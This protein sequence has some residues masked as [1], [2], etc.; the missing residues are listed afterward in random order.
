MEAPVIVRGRL[1]D[2]IQ[3]VVNDLQATRRFYEAVFGVLGIAIGGEG[4]DY[5]WADELFVSSVDSR[6]AAGKPR[7]SIASPLSRL[8]PAGR[9]TA[10]PVSGRIT[11]ATTPPSCWIR[12]ATTSKW[13]TT[14]RPRAPPTPSESRSDTCALRPRGRSGRG[15][16]RLLGWRVLRHPAPARQPRHLRDIAH[17][18]QH[19]LGHGALRRRRS[20]VE[21]YRVR[22][23]GDVRRG[24]ARVLGDRSVAGCIR[25]VPEQIVHLGCPG[26][27]R[28]RKIAVLRGRAARQSRHAPC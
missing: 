10:A 18:P 17:L 6:A 27:A 15:P 3:L 25:T 14:D 28:A 26:G 20:H 22:A 23:T 19:R 4:S 12:Q 8:R 11:P 1:I 16:P 5:F 9:T 2:H 7:R 24:A 13:S 21:R